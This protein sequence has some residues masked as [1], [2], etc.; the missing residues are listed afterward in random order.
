MIPSGEKLWQPGAN[1]PLER[2]EITPEMKARGFVPVGTL[3]IDT[4][5]EPRRFLKAQGYFL[6]QFETSTDRGVPVHHPR[7]FKPL[8]RINLN[9]TASE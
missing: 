7:G 9:G 4:K 3:S 5:S 2:V 6:K 8:P 1:R